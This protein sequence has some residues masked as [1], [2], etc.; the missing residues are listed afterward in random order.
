L[1]YLQFVELANEN[2]FKTL[3]VPKRPFRIDFI[4]FYF[5]FKQYICKKVP[6]SKHVNGHITKG[7]KVFP[8]TAMNIFKS[9]I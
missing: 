6:V 7:L 2:N 3:F 9:K 1:I 4:S 8:E 5:I